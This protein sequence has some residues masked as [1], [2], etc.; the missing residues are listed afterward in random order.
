MIRRAILARVRRAG[1]GSAVG[2][3]GLAAFRELADV[4]AHRVTRGE[5]GGQQ[6]FNDRARPLET[7]GDDVDVVRQ[8]RVQQRHERGRSGADGLPVAVFCEGF[9]RMCFGV[10]AARPL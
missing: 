10:E 2:G 3:N 1:A 4:G 6:L 5:R 8:G 7:R 9:Q